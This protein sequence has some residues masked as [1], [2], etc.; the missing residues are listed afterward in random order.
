MVRKSER[1][2][3]DGTCT[4]RKHVFACVCMCACVPVRKGLCNW[5]E[6]QKITDGMRCL[7][8]CRRVTGSSLGSGKSL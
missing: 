5:R 3:H 8:V 1:A 2:R 6:W 4:E 7:D